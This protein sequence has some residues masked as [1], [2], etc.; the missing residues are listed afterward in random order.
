MLTA[1]ANFELELN[2]VKMYVHEL[3]LPGHTA[4]KVVFSSN[5]KPIIVTRTHDYDR[6]FWTSVPE[7]RQKEAEG[8]GA[9][10]EDYFKKQNK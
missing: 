2:G 6:V 9:L 4:F 8:V 5:R 7:G 1:P 3:D 10:I